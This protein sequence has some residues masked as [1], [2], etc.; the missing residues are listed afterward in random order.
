[1]RAVFLGLNALGDTLCTT[2]AIR[3]Y[4]RKYPEATII[5]VTQ[6]A[7]FC[8]VLDKNPDIDLLLYSEHLYFNGLPGPDQMVAWLQTLPIDLRESATLY[9]LDLNLV[10][11]TA[12]VFQSHIS[13]AFARL[14]QVDLE[15]TRP[16]IFL[17]EHDRRAAQVFARR[18]YV[19][20]SPHS[21]SNPE[22]TDGRGRRKDWP[23]ENWSELAS[24]IAAT[25][26]FDL[27]AI[28]SERDTWID[29]PHARRLHGLPI[30]TLAA[31]LEQAACVVT[32]ENGIAHLCAAVRASTVELYS[33]L[34]PLAWA[35][36]AEGSRTRLLYGDPLE[37]TCE[38]VYREFQ[39]FVCATA[40]S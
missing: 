16:L 20:L 21:V 11:Q 1:M 7:P 24:R 8:R 38:Q 23:I 29:I 35:K 40:A 3:A 27:Y 32:V 15:S 4:R 26:E 9:R 25:G 5:Y 17:D 37:T 34:M 2:P 6:S 33:N 30:R 13:E 19:V 12:E 36:P 28:G 18:P 31:L 22:R 10:C 14:V 39:H